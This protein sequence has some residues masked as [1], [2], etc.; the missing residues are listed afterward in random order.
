M[1]T[2]QG[3]IISPLLANIALDGMERLFGSERPNGRTISPATRRGAN[4]GVGLIR[5]A[6]D[7]VVTAPSREVLEDY[8]VP[9][10]TEFLASRGLSLS[11]AK[12]RIVHINDGFN[13]LGFTVRRFP[14]GK[15]LTPPQ[16]EKV[17][18]HQ[19]RLSAFLRAH[20]QLPTTEV[21]R[22][23]ALRNPLIL[24]FFTDQG[25]AADGLGGAGRLWKVRGRFRRLG[26]GSEQGGAS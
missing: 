18:E 11:E 2:P 17:I 15:L 5:Y 4:R 16:K 21:I 8:V 13:F 25:F 6:D 14:N 26:W 22:A 12:T 19:R 20:R 24:S 9:R 23:L 3:G 1:G 7:F 10:L